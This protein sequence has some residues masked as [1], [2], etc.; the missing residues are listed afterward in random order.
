M[1]RSIRL[2]T[3]AGAVALGLG[4]ATASV[5]WSSEALARTRYTASWASVDR[6][7][8]EPAES[9]DMPRLVPQER[10]RRTPRRVRVRSKRRPLAAPARR[11]P[12]SLSW[13]LVSFVREV[14]EGNANRGS[15]DDTG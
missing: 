15:T 12:C 4:V 5:S 13:A 8:P 9:A 2:R 7:P 6:T 10:S 3:L 14:V 1:T 11:S